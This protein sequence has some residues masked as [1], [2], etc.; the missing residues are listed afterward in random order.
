MVIAFFLNDMN[1]DDVDQLSAKLERAE[2]KLRDRKASTHTVAAVGTISHYQRRK[3]TPRQMNIEETSDLSM[4]I[5][6]V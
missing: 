6:T 5:V 2:F 3:R 1:V 4:N